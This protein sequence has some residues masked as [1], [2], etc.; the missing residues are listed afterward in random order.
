MSLE[1]VT[2]ANKSQGMFE[3]LV[4]N[5]FGVPVTVLGWGPSGMGSVIST[6]Q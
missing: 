4:N 2:Y 5:E 1:I 3:E 6:R